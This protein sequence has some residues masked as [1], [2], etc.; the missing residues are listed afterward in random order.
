MREM[1]GRGFFDV[2]NIPRLADVPIAADVWRRAYPQLEGIREREFTRLDGNALLGNIFYAF[3]DAIPELV[4][5]RYQT[6]QADLDLKAERNVVWNAGAKAVIRRTIWEKRLDGSVTA[7]DWLPSGGGKAFSLAKPEFA[8]A[9][10]DDFT[11][12]KDVRIGNSS[13][14]PF[15]FRQSGLYAHADRAK[16]PVSATPRRVEMRLIESAF[17]Y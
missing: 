4:P 3:P 17:A 8:D 10:R 6:Q 14:G 9:R 15:L 7:E 2:R 1:G 12:A 5:L 16:W 13:L 11:P